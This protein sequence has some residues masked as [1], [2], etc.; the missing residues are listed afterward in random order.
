MPGIFKINTM[1]SLRGYSKNSAW[2]HFKALATWLTLVGFPINIIYIISRSKQCWVSL[3]AL[4]LKISTAGCLCGSRAESVDSG[5]L[6]YSKTY[7]YTWVKPC[8]CACK[9]SYPH[10]FL[11]TPWC[12]LSASILRWL[13]NVRMTYPDWMRI[14]PLAVVTERIKI[15]FLSYSLKCILWTPE[16][17]T[18]VTMHKWTER[19]PWFIRRHSP[20]YQKNDC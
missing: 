15:E 10:H 8:H 12:Q 16:C 4:W 5:T 9:G 18:A 11:P 20:C 3:K 14:Q 13:R 17:S 6:E 1:F 7:Y 19:M 2:K